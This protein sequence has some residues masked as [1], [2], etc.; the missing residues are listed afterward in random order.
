M[1][2]SGNILYLWPD[3]AMRGLAE[4]S[5]NASFI[6]R[7]YKPRDL[8]KGISVFE[9]RNDEVW[10]AR[11]NIRITDYIKPINGLCIDQWPHL[12]GSFA[13]AKG[14]SKQL[15]VPLDI[16][17]LLPS[18][19][20]ISPEVWIGFADQI[21]NGNVWKVIESYLNP[22]KESSGRSREVDRSERNAEDLRKRDEF[23]VQRKIRYNL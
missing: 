10:S 11:F 4:S 15:V 19:T 8:E 12:G 21:E 22:K 7:E 16:E 5:S 2:I 9:R 1:N 20:K 18:V 13:F 17:N 14:R 6:L 23:L 3:R